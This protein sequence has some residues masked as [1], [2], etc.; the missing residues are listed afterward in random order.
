MPNKRFDSLNGM[1]ELLKS[2]GFIVDG[3]IP[4]SQAEYDWFVAMCPPQPV[5]EQYDP[6]KW[7]FHGYPLVVKN[8]E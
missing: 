8:H 5:G 3:T 7:Y 1:H 4:V 2:E 6:A